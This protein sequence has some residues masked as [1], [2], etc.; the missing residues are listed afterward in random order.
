MVCSV[1]VYKDLVVFVF[2]SEIYWVFLHIAESKIGLIFKCSTWS[3][4]LHVTLLIL[5]VFLVAQRPH[6]YGSH[7]RCGAIIICS[8]N[9]VKQLLQLISSLDLKELY[10]LLFF[11]FIRWKIVTRNKANIQT[12]RGDRIQ[13]AVLHILCKWNMT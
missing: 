9:W 13:E 2:D 10:Q 7:W 4:T 1:S 3:R 8:W 5:W 6:S 12:L 11:K